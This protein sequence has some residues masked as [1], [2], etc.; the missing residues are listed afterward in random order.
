MPFKEILRSL[1]LERGLTQDE[2]SKDIGIKR[3]AISMYENG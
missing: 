1:R 2:L 3:S